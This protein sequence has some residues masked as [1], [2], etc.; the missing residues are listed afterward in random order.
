M[1]F[2]NFLSALGT[3]WDWG[4]CHCLHDR[5][6]KDMFCGLPK[7]QNKSVASNRSFCNAEKMEN[8]VQYVSST[9]TAVQQQEQ[10]LH[11]ILAPCAYF[12][13]AED[14]DDSRLYFRNL[15]WIDNSPH[16]FART[17]SC[18]NNS[19]GPFAG[20]SPG[21]YNLNDASSCSYLAL[22]LLAAHAT[23]ARVIAFTIVLG[24]VSTC[25]GIRLLLTDKKLPPGGG[26]GQRLKKFVYVQ[27]YFL[28]GENFSDVGGWV[29]RG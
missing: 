23:N 17:T 3:G 13:Q 12:H 14:E 9:H 28:P 2:R 16:T 6:Q 20:L 18:Q 26:G 21:S 10:M 4:C 11:P 27:S 1:F 8:H 24:T 7:A 15:A 29:S 19:R 5:M 22:C 25:L